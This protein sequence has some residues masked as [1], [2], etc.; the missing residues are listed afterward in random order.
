MV[1]SIPQHDHVSSLLIGIGHTTS[2]GS[3]LNIGKSTTPASNKKTPVA[4][5]QTL[6]PTALNTTASINGHSQITTT[7]YDVLSAGTTM[8][9]TTNKRVTSSGKKI[10][11]SGKTNATQTDDGVLNSSTTTVEI[12]R[13]SYIEA[14]DSGCE[15]VGGLRIILALVFVAFL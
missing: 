2:G 3:T 15:R 10:I 4:D 8:S 11:I 12:N 5:T 7:N 9:R 1:W 13:T 14:P 6:G